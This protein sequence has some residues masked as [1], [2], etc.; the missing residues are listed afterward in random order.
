MVQITNIIDGIGKRI[1]KTG[2]RAFS[3]AYKKAR[4]IKTKGK[5]SKIEKKIVEDYKKLGFL[6]LKDEN[7][8]LFDDIAPLIKE[9]ADLMD[10][11]TSLR[12]EINEIKEIDY[13]LYCGAEIKNGSKFCPY[14]GKEITHL[15]NRNIIKDN[16]PENSIE[17]YSSK[18]N[19]LLTLDTSRS[20]KKKI[21]IADSRRLVKLNKE[22]NKKLNQL[23]ANCITIGKKYYDHLNNS[24]SGYANSII[25]R[26]LEN[27]EKIKEIKNSPKG[28]KTDVT[29]PDCQEEISEFYEYCP[30]CG[31]NICEITSEIFGSSIVNDQQYH[32]AAGALVICTFVILI[33]V[34]GSLCFFVRDYNK[35]ID[36]FVEA[37]Y[38]DD[39]ELFY[40]L[41]PEDVISTIGSSQ[42]FLDSTTEGMK[43]KEKVLKMLDILMPDRTEGPNNLY[44]NRWT[45]KYEIVKEAEITMNE[46]TSLSRVPYY[47]YN[48]SKEI[49]EMKSVELVVSIVND[50]KVWRKDSFNII[51]GNKGRDW[52]LISW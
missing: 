14:C 25:I 5:I 20:N 9:S 31:R 40:S 17:I 35:T 15:D 12:K 42:W 44:G 26:I 33:G 3:T 39:T 23:N 27:K 47:S 28:I 24:P 18:D 21:N 1:T 48:L 34:I 46:M 36:L 10:E 30:S 41:L 52:Y 16:S 29:C 6:Y 11:I 22:V 43:T 32:R 49:K 4:D 51:L 13:C 38:T 45:Y 8:I 50:G 7:S 19:N 2:L 37:C